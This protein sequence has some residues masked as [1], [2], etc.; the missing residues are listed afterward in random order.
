MGL[1]DKI[2][3]AVDQTTGSAKA[4]IGAI[5]D[6]PALQAE[7]QAQNAVGHAQQSDSD[8]RSLE[9]RARDI[10]ARPN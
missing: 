4:K 9:D 10:A 8:P 1:A 5:T 6:N 3:A 7:G 2:R